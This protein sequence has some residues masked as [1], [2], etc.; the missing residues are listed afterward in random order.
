MVTEARPTA[1]FSTVKTA[2]QAN[3]HPFHQTRP[4]RNA[5]ARAAIPTTRTLRAPTHPEVSM[6]RPL[7]L[8]L[9]AACQLAAGPTSKTAQEQ[10]QAARPVPAGQSVAIFAAGCFW[11]SEKDF[12]KVPGVIEVESG[13]AGGT[14]DKPTYREVGAGTTGHTE[15]VRVIYD[16]K[17][18][19]YEQLL[20]WYWHHVDPFDAGG[21]FC[22][23][24]SQYRPAILPLDEAQRKAAEASKFAIEQTFARPVAVKLEQPGTFWLAEAY[25]QDFYKTNAD[26]YERYRRGCGRDARVEAVW[27]EVDPTGV[28]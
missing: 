28:H 1:A 5:A 12:E 7:L 22:D 8:A 21:Q 9:V 6:F 17:K 10:P 3:A 13:F 27:A 24:G 15:A 2:T 25:H 16:P 4:R 18:V 14:K 23:R 11:C 26:H 19:S 20:D